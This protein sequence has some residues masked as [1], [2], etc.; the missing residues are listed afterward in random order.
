VHTWLTDST[1]DAAVPILMA[2]CFTQTGSA[3]Q[4]II[5]LHDKQR[6]GINGTPLQMPS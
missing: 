3:V 5:N 2:D 4:G 6:G 1:D